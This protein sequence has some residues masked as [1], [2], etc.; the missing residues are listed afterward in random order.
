VRT[1]VRERREAGVYREAWDGRDDGQH[2]VGSGV[3]YLHLVTG[4][5]RFTKTLVYLK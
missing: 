5:R 2:A 1:L 3:F 4:G